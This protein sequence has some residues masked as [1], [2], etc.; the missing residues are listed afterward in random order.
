[1]I[2]T[3]EERNRILKLMA[4]QNI[5]QR[6]MEKI[7]GIAVTDIN[8]LLNGKKCCFPGWRKRIAAALGLKESELFSKQEV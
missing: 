3:A 7:T 1:M 8:Q 6:K 4:N 2:L 5:S